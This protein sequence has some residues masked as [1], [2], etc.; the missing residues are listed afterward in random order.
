MAK[1]ETTKVGGSDYA[2]VADRLAEFRKENPRASIETEYHLTENGGAIFRAKILKDKRDEFSAEATGSAA[3]PASEMRKPKAFEKLET[4]A[5]GR[6]LSLM[7]Y[8]NNGEIA[9]SEEMEEFEAYKEKKT[10]ELGEIAKKIKATTTI[11]ELQELW[12]SLDKSLQGEKILFDAKN[13]RKQELA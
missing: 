8:L 10:Q 2:K 1:I 3:Y 9:S 5:V 7:G 13:K 11:Q 6:A 4:I 12:L